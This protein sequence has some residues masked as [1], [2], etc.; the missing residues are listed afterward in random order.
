MVLPHT[1]EFEENPHQ[2]LREVE[3]T[4]IP[5][6]HVV[7]MGFN[8]YSLWGMT[9]MFI[10]WRNRTPWCGHFYSTLRIKDWLA[11]LGFDTVLQKSYFFR[12]PLQHEGS[13]E[14]LSFMERYGS[15]WWPFPGGGY[16]LVAKKRLTT[17]T[18][19]KPRWRSS[20]RFL[21]NGLTEPTANRN[22]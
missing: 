8:P 17:L 16:I 20:R 5:E 2:I 12:P 13:L 19:I 18:P 21:G 4:L 14:R 3:R 10:G 9:R 22:R 11:L 1:L 7:I 15:R 6:G